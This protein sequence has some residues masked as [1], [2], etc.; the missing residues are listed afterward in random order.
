MKQAFLIFSI[1]LFLH[2]SLFSQQERTTNSWKAFV[3]I[4]Y[5]NTTSDNLSE[6]YTLLAERYRYNGLPLETQTEFGPTLLANAGIIF[7]ILE[8]IGAGI[9]FG[10][11]YSPAYTN[12]K[13]YAGTVKI[14]GSIS[15]YEILLKVHYIP[16][17]IGDFSIVICPQFGASHASVLITQEVRFNDY[18]QSNYDW[19]MSKG[20]WGP[21]VQATIGTSVNLGEFFAGF[22]GGYRYTRIQVA[23]QTEE[24]TTGTAEVTQVMDIGLNGFI[25]L[26]S[27][28]IKF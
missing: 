11:L 14:N 15:S 10:Y 23:E 3:S 28:G 18:Q 20:G 5:G 21:C 4:G 24:S 27:F 8:R 6:Y 13:D 1:S 16:G 9:S 26:L 19:K 7:N 17:K 2:Q 22:E 12:Y 25:S